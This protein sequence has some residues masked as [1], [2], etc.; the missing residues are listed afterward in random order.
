LLAARAEGA[1]GLTE[2]DVHAELDEVILSKLL[3]TPCGMPMHCTPVLC[4][5]DWSTLHIDAA[6]KGNTATTCDMPCVWVA[7]PEK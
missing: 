1:L 7:E 6:G 5:E 4:G 3:H 2:A